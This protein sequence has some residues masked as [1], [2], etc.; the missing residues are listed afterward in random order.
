VSSTLKYG[1]FAE[2]EEAT[3]RVRTAARPTPTVSRRA[4]D[5]VTPSL[6]QALTF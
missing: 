2:R 5:I 3:R 4:L 6:L 1:V